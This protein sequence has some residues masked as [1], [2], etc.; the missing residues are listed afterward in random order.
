MN[1]KI[2]IPF[3][4]LFSMSEILPMDREYNYFCAGEDNSFEIGEEVEID[5][6]MTKKLFSAAYNYQPKNVATMLCMINEIDPKSE[7]FKNIVSNNYF[8]RALILVVYKNQLDNVKT[9]LN[10]IN[11]LRTDSPE[12]FKNILSSDNFVCTL[13]LAARYGHY[14][15]F[16]TLLAFK[17]EALK[18]FD[19]PALDQLNEE[20][21]SDLPNKSNLDNF[22]EKLIKDIKNKKIKNKK[23]P[24]SLID[25]FM[26]DS[27]DINEFI[28]SGKLNLF[29][30]KLNNKDLFSV[31]TS[32][33]KSCHKEQRNEAMEIAV[34]EIIDKLFFYN[35]IDLTDRI[36]YILKIE[37]VENITIKI[38]DYLKTE[39][40]APR[41]FMHKFH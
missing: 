14:S 26:R 24:L 20:E 25:Y 8:V 38:K 10:I 33:L 13:Y 37:G 3:I 2:L 11:K 18:Y 12:F 36:E 31:F 28:E 1:I 7:A 39:I 6:E 41:L 30:E 16:V 17:I 22:I 15:C 21:E 5:N 23:V 35:D 29:I 40:I 19:I 27:F 34:D 4:F 32:K 9:M